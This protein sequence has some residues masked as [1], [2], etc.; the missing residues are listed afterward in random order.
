[1][2]DFDSMTLGFNGFTEQL[3]TPKPPTPHDHNIFPG[4][5]IFLLVLVGLGALS[6]IGRFLF[7]RYK[8]KRQRE[9]FLMSND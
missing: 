1:M 2:W 7:N 6:V 5:A 3:P 4:W 8:Q 9:D